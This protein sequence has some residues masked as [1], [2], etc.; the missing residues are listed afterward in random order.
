MASTKR[1]VYIYI[2]NKQVN[3]DIKSI[4]AESRKLRNE[5]GRLTRGSKEY[6][7]KMRELKRTNRIIRDHNKEIRGMKGVWGSL[8]TE[9][10]QFG[11]LA[12]GALGINEMINQFGRLIQR[13][14]QFDDQLAD[15]MKT[16]GLS[17]DQVKELSQ[18]LG[19]LN[20]RSSRSELLGLA[21]IAGKLGKEGKRDIL[22][23]V[24]SADRINVALSE[25]LGGNVEETIRQLGK[26]TDLFDL[27]DLFGSAE[28]LE[29]TG[30]A[31]NAIGASSTANEPYLVEFAKRVG[32]I[33]PQAKVS[34]Q[35]V[36][37]LASALDQL[38][39]SS[40]VSSTVYAQVV[41]DMF[42]NTSTYA[43]VARMDVADF[44]KL[45][46]TDANEAFLKVLEGLHGNNE[47]YATMVKK[48]DELGLEGKRSIS[49]LGALSSNTALIRQEQK[50]AN[51]EFEKGTSLQ[52]EFAVKNTNV[53]A[54]LARV[55]R[56]INKWFVNSTLIKWIGNVVGGL[57]GLI[58]KTKTYSERL[59]DTHTELNVLVDM[60]T[61]ANLAEAERKRIID[62][63]QNVYP[64]FLANLDLEKATTA[65]IR[66]RLREVNEELMAQIVLKRKDEE[67]EEQREKIANA[68]NDRFEKQKEIIGLINKAEEDYGITID[69]NAN[70]AT[71]YQ[72]AID[73]LSEKT[74]G[75]GIALD[76]VKRLMKDLSN[77]Y[78]GLSTGFNK[79]SREYEEEQSLLALLTE[80]RED[81]Y[82]Q[83]LAEGMIRERL[84]GL[85]TEQNE[86]YQNLRQQLAQVNEAMTAMP[87][88]SQA[89]Q[90][91]EQQKA[92]IEAN[93]AALEKL[94]KGMP[95]AGDNDEDPLT[96]TED[97]AKKA[98]KEVKTLL[99][100][101]ESLP[102]KLRTVTENEGWEEFEA[103]M[104]S[105][106]GERT[107][108]LAGLDE[109]QAF[110]NTLPTAA[111]QIDYLQQLILQLQ[112][113][114]GNT[115]M[116]GQLNQLLASIA[117]GATS[118]TWRR[119]SEGASAFSN[120]SNTIANGISFEIDLMRQRL[121]LMED[122]GASEGKIAKE[123]AKYQAKANAMMMAS[124]RIQRLSNAATAVGAAYTQIDALN[125]AIKAATAQGKAP[126]P[127]NLPMILG[128]VAAIGSAIV[129]IRQLF[130]E[131][132]RTPQMATGGYAK[133][134]GEQDGRTYRAKTSRA[135]TGGFVKE[136]TLLVGERNLEYWVPDYELRKPEVLDMVN[137]LEAIRTG[138]QPDASSPQKFMGGFSAMDIMQQQRI[139]NLEKQAP[140]EKESSFE[141][142]LLS[143]LEKNN[144]LL[145]KLDRYGVRGQW[146]WDSFKEG[147]D[148]A[149]RAEGR[150]GQ[151]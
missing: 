105:V 132:P 89:L 127:A 96:T 6:N 142:R 103:F 4:A 1:S 149:N 83:L 50:L 74:N 133:V 80:E 3:N 48:L 25:D 34:L 43:K 72:Q 140:P 123:R 61:T 79:L 136:P 60:L 9:V 147:F 71:K 114:P 98:T 10:K 84:N 53:A 69:Q 85:T 125:L 20:T 24:E 92:A 129:A 73:Q 45:L 31:I 46:N 148:K 36:L 91:L 78:N 128:T 18:E 47:G 109:L 62:D 124:I 51:E 138:R 110:I 44:A 8:R 108:P 118:E 54:Q 32:G 5:V 55:G 81:M 49:V 102:Q 86:A 38:G 130:A 40:E 76:P 33:A 56:A 113:E 57:E 82:Q 117:D 120:L 13:T 30:S 68:W 37:G 150:S 15:V 135:N 29:R 17:K 151:V 122:T 106:F 27:D 11:A 100:E 42:K 99:E 19:T 26:L 104:D 28:A 63:I 97:K 139:K 7:E 52:E 111:E 144:T 134:K 112:E 14:A 75:L 2:N 115:A 95:G 70:L 41:P 93:I 35:E 65:D 145:D 146:E 39:Q 66:D 88:G 12:L 58:V 77:A 126:F 21:R 131:V 16:T 90:L 23:F 137:V 67:I 141:E 87:E 64:D 143:A 116:V 101:L 59:Q 94:S 119:V 107:D 22:E 121:R